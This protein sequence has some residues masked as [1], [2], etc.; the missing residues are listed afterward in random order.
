M[1]METLTITQYSSFPL[2]SPTMVTVSSGWLWLSF[3][4][5]FFISAHTVFK[6]AKLKAL[7]PCP[8]LSS[9]LPLQ[10]VR[11]TQALPYHSQAVNCLYC[12]SSGSSFPCFNCISNS[13]CLPCRIAKKVKNG[14]YKFY[15]HNISSENTQVTHVA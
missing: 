5:F 10:V 15:L 12:T 13:A 3:R 7:K 11:N 14:S 8:P 2:A 4:F 1:H 9:Y 6:L